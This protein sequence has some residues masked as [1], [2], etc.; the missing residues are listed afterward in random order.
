[1]RRVCKSISARRVT[2][3]ASP[4]VGPSGMGLVQ[5]V[6]TP[7]VLPCMHQGSG[8]GDTGAPCWLHLEGLKRWDVK[9]PVNGGF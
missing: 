3:P 2:A 4:P 5:L 1:M 7:G 6:L 8:G 9:R